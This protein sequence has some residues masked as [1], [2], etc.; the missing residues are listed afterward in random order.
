MKKYNATLLY[1][2]DLERETYNISLPATGL[3]LVY[4]DRG[5]NIYRLIG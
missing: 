2:G 4:S 1:V 5:T 3:E